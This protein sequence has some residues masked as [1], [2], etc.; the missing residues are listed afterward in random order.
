LQIAPQEIQGRVVDEAMIENL[1]TERNGMTLSGEMD[2]IVQVIE[3]LFP[4]PASA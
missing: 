1:V 3:T 4:V 2:T